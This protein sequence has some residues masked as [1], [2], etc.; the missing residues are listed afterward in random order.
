MS[1]F[2]L[3]SAT[4]QSATLWRVDDQYRIQ[5]NS[6]ETALAGSGVRVARS[7]SEHSSRAASAFTLVENLAGKNGVR[8]SDLVFPIKEKIKKQVQTFVTF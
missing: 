7:F 1:L 5:L 6:S 3:G 8:D 4:F 2:H